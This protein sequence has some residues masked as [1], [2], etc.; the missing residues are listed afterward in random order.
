MISEYVNE[1]IETD[2]TKTEH[3]LSGWAVSGKEE[4]ANAKILY[5]TDGL[6]KEYLLHDEDFITTHTAVNKYIVF[7]IDE[8]HERSVN[9]DLC[10]ALLARLLTIKPELK[11]KMKIIIS[12]ATLD[13]SVSRPF[14]K[15]PHVGFAEFKMPQIGYRYKVTPIPRLKENILDVVQEIYRKRQPNDQILCFVNSVSEV[16]QCCRLLAE[17]SRQTIIAYPLVQSQSSSAQ[18]SNIQNGSVFFS[19]TV[20]ETSLTFPSLKYVID[21]GRINIPIY[22]PELKRTVLEEVRAA[23]STIKQR[24]GRLG[25]TTDG[26]YYYLYDF[27]VEDK[28]YPT[29]HIC[30]SDLTHIE[31]SLRRSP[32]K[33]GLHYMQ[34]FLPNSPLLKV[35][36]ATVDELRILGK[37]I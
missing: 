28:P 4:N 35:I 25:R 12:S 15:I 7:F 36:D 17:L 13:E 22:D 11:L 21:T 18:Q 32:I 2:T 26:I 37:C 31:F 10:L 24:I 8:V 14:C 19:T 5:L 29:P 30:V 6:L 33:C 20:A 27:R 23:E 1:T 3:G 34:Q 9:I 16:Y